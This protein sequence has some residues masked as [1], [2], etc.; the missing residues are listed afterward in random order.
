MN[1]KY[2]SLLLMVLLCFSSVTNAKNKIDVITNVSVNIINLDLSLDDVIRSTATNAVVSTQKKNTKPDL[3]GAEVGVGLIDGDLY[4]GFSTLITGQSVSRFSNDVDGTVTKS[5]ELNIRSAFD[6]FV[7]YS[8]F[9][10][11]SVYLG[12]TK[13]TSSYGDKVSTKELGPFLGVRYAHRIGSSS[14]VTFNLSYSQLKTELELKDDAY[15]NV[16]NEDGYSISTDSVGFSYTLTWLKS[17]DRGRSF[18]VRLKGIDLTIENGQTSVTDSGTKTN[19]FIAT[20]G[21]RQ[22]MISISFGVGF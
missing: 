2:G 10:N 4:Y 17:L 21:G 19:S 15:I 8:V 3:Q 9:D 1:K 12:L 5:P 14:S 13:G 7:G 6:V 20:V 11:G 16:N 18:F 22:K